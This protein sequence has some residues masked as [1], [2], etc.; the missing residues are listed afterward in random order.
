MKSRATPG[1]LPRFRLRQAY[2]AKG[3]EADPQCVPT[4]KVSRAGDV[5]RKKNKQ[6]ISPKVVLEEMARIEGG[7]NYVGA[8][9]VAIWHLRAIPPSCASHHLVQKRSNR[10]AGVPLSGK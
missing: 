5:L 8:K 1:A 4:Y 9:L 6:T 7:D 2:G 10:Q 3:S